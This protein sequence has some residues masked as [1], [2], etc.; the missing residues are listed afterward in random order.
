MRGSILG[1]VR[2][3]CSIL[4]NKSVVPGVTQDKTSLENASGKKSSKEPTMGNLVKRNSG[5]KASAG[6]MSGSTKIGQMMEHE[7]DSDT[8]YLSR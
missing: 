1:N 5:S 7:S 8:E 6:N 4:E 3:T 2:T